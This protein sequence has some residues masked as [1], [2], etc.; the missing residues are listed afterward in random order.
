MYLLEYLA[1]GLFYLPFVATPLII[2]YWYAFVT[3]RMNEREQDGN[4]SH[5]ERNEP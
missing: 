5:K 2:V 3:A 4:E 1:V